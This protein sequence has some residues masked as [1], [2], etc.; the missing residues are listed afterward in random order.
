MLK[1]LLLPDNYE[2]FSDADKDFI[3]SD[4][5]GRILDVDGINWTKLKGSYFTCLAAEQNTLPS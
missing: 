2:D 5:V 3:R 1:L 4:L